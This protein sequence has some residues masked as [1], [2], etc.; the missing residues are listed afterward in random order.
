MLERNFDDPNFP[1]K[2][3]AKD[4]RLFLSV[5]EQLGL[6]TCGLQ[7]VSELIDK[8]LAQGL[9]NTDYSALMAA[10]SPK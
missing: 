2:H 8:T 6:E 3:L 4:T 1:T 7:G 10:V 5:A 9:D